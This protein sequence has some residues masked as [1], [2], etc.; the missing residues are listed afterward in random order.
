[1][2]RALIIVVSLLG[3]TAVGRAEPPRTPAPAGAVVYIESP[4]DG[5][6]VHDPVTVKFGLAGMGV[7]PAG[8]THPDTGHHHLLIDVDPL[9]PLDRPLPAN[10]RIRHFGGGQTQTIL[11]LPSGRHTLR[12]IL[13]DANHVPH[14]PPVV[15]EAIHVT[16]SEE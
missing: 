5:E 2:R 12:L 16:V 9:P 14:D 13:G 6:T 8:V 10:D 15:S 4:A 1:M 3:W 7:A 11:Q